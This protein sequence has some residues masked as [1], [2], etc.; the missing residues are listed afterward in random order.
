MYFYEYKEHSVSHIH[1]EI[2]KHELSANWK[3]AVEESM[4]FKI[5]GLN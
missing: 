1:I 3:L 5:N 4:V 2:H